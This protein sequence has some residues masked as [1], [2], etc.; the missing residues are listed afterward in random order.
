MMP[1]ESEQL[2]FSVFFCITVLSMWPHSHCASHCSQHSVFISGDTL[3]LPLTSKVLKNT[4]FF[5]L[6][7]SHH[8]LSTVQ[9]LCLTLT[10]LS[11]WFDWMHWISIQRSIFSLILLIFIVY[12]KDVYNF[13]RFRSSSLQ[14]NRMV[15]KI[16]Q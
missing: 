8:F 16:R 11:L 2:D 7:T 15:K 13:S 3:I 10:H 12:Q 1:E 4:V 14:R 6:S 9:L 5:N